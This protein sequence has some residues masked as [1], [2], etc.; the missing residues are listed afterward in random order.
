VVEVVADGGGWKVG[1]F[2]KDK[3]KGFLKKIM[4]FAFS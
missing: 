3:K 2:A 1:A 4:V